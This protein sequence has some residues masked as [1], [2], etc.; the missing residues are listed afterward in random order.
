[1]TSSVTYVNTAATLRVPG[2]LKDR[3]LFQAEYHNVMQGRPRS[4]L[5]NQ[6]AKFNYSAP[7]V[8]V[9]GTS[10]SL[11][12]YDGQTARRKSSKV[13]LFSQLYPDA[14]GCNGPTVIN[15][16]QR[17]LSCLRLCILSAT[18]P[19]AVQHD[20]RRPRSFFYDSDELGLQM[21]PSMRPLWYL[22][23]I[24]W[25]WTFELELIIRSSERRLYLILLDIL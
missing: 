10:S 21:I 5:A 12:R 11:F 6:A 22:M 13:K 23:L 14:A 19:I 24:F 8:A 17:V 25:H 16:R 1:M 9:L 7:V 2:K 3:G 18:A 15:A 4:R 20:M